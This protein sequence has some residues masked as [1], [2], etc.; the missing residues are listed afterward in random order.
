MPLFSSRRKAPAGGGDLLS[1]TTLDE[2][3]VISHIRTRTLASIVY[4][5]PP[6]SGP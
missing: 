1:L 2:A 6:Q 4:E 3:N 5:M